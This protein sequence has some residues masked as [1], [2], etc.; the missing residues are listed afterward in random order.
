MLSLRTSIWRVV[1][2]VEGA[3]LENS[4]ALWK[5]EIPHPLKLLGIRYGSDIGFQ[6]FLSYFSLL[7]PAGNQRDLSKS[8]Y[9]E[10]CPSGRRYSTR[11]AAR[12]QI[13]PGFE[14]LTLRHRALQRHSAGLFLCLFLMQKED[15]EPTASRQRKSVLT[16]IPN[17]HRG[18]P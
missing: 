2:V 9:M 7:F 17:V 8:I 4:A 15:S 3:A 5:Q 1:R 16:H 12:S 10:S 11:N 13:L 14:S 6:C 18:L